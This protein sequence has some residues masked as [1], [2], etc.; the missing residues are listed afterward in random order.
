MDSKGQVV[1]EQ[2]VIDTNTSIDVSTLSSGLYVV[3]VNENVY[4]LVIE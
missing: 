3:K 1:L 2:N 4:K